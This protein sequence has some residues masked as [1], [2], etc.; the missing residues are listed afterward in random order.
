MKKPNIKCEK[1]D[2]T[3][4]LFFLLVVFIA[5][6]STLNTPY[7][8]DEM[9]WI[10]AAHWLS[11]VNLLRSIPGFHPSTTF[12]GHPPALHLSL[13]SLYKLFGESVWL[14][15]LLILCFSFLGAYFT[16]L[17]GTFL[18]GRKVGIFSALFLFFSAIYFAQSGM[19][20][21]DI[22]VTALGVMSIHFALR[23]KYIP[24]LLCAVYMVMIKETAIAILFSLLIY[25]FLTDGHRSKNAFREILKYG[26][27]LL[28]IA[29]FSILQKFTTG[30]FCCIY[31]F[32]FQLF[33]LQPNL[34]IH[35]V[36]EISKWLFFYQYRY[37]FTFL[38]VLNFIINKAH[39]S[40]K[41]LL[42]FLL[43]FILSGY[44]FSFLYFLPRYLLP[45]L[46]YFYIM[47]AWSLI[48][49][50]KSKRLQTVMGTA[51]TAVLI[52]SLSGTVLQ[53]NNEWDM[54]YLEIVKIHKTMCQYIEEEFPNARVLTTFP[55]TQQLRRPYLGYVKKP[56][57]VVPFKE[58]RGLGDFDLILFSIPSDFNQK[59]VLRDYALRNN[60]DLIKRL[61]K[62]KV[63]S[64]LYANIQQK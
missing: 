45:T 27:P 16:Y 55:H 63:T 2:I 56:V 60:L 22:P 26:L 53:G 30:K 54:K 9:G 50:I 14:S 19:F 12:W 24:Y 6:F 64:E 35:Q 42:L 38:I 3:A 36:F 49:L 37:I 62:D 48:E 59:N 4:F 40:Q 1:Y 7:Y 10:R 43:I 33:E 58:E 41:E 11:Q 13:A 25:S 52:Y 61:E 20:L 23:K 46:P 57:K 15:H 17:L 8:W 44:S 32:K 29:A 18:Y 31:P 47:G 5:K 34:V 51:I 39:K 21:G 28:V